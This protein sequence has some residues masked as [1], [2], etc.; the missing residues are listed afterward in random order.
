MHRSA[1]Q[2][3]FFL[4]PGFYFLIRLVIQTKIQLCAP[5]KKSKRKWHKREI[6]QLSDNQKYHPVAFILASF[7]TRLVGLDLEPLLLPAIDDRLL[8]NPK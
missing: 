7:L 1:R 5:P 8:A 2:V 4:S 6:L 3:S